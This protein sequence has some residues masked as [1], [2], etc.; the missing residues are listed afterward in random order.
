MSDLNLEDRIQENGQKFILVH[1][2]MS[3]WIFLIE[4][5]DFVDESVDKPFVALSI[6]IPPKE[7]SRQQFQDFEEEYLFDEE[8]DEFG[9][10]SE[11]DYDTDEFEQGFEQF[12]E[13]DYW[14]HLSIKTP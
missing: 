13:N 7:E 5:L 6:G 10:Y 8:E 1:D 14:C 9:E 12:D 3:M 4:L 11:E 2:F